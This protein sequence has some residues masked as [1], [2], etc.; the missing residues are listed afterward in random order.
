MKK[1]INLLIAGLMAWGCFACSEDKLTPSEPNHTFAARPGAQ[2]EELRRE[3]FDKH[4]CYIIFNDTLRHDYMGTDEDGDAFYDTEL[5]D[6]RWTI[7][8]V[9][10]DNEYYTYFFE[11]FTTPEEKSVRAEYMGDVVDL[12]DRHNLTKPY[13]ILVVKKIVREDIDWGDQEFYDMLS[14]ERCFIVNLTDIVD[15]E[16]AKYQLAAEMAG[17]GLRV[18][19]EQELAPFFNLTIEELMRGYDD[20]GYYNNYEDEEDF[21]RGG[22][23]EYDSY[24]Y[25]S[26]GADVASYLKLLLTKTQ[27]EVEQE[28]SDY[29]VI[30]QKYAIIREI[31]DKAGIEY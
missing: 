28:Y 4:N 16:D 8:G 6:P 20:Y 19:Y 3:F 5:V 29:D 18:K 10:G 1:Q 7:F 24:Y 26:K 25:P 14:T 22:L 9:S 23:L 27:E 12:L 17:N 11:Y 2:D 30:L 15:T 21:K 31:A 13:S